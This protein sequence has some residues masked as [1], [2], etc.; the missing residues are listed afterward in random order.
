MS[1]QVSVRF[2]LTRREFLAAARVVNGRN[3][4]I[5]AFGLGVGLVLIVAAVIQNGTLF[6]LGLSLAVG[7]L[8]ALALTPIVR[9]RQT[10]LAKAEQEHTF[11]DDGCVIVVEGARSE[12]AWS[13]YERSFVTG[14]AYLLLHTWSQ[15]NVI[16]KRAFGGQEEE[17]FIALLRRHVRT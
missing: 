2:T 4:R 7:A 15:F 9:W 3:P 1:D 5:R 16:P 14:S 13:F 8:I 12:V 6:G 11:S 17:V 10:R